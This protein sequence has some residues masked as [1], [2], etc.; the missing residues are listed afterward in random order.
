MNILEAIIKG[1]SHENGGSLENLTQQLANVYGDN[2]FNGLG[3][4]MGGYI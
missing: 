2:G 3:A 1:L 4:A